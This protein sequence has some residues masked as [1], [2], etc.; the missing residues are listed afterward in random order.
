[1]WT[2]TQA[3]VIENTTRF[4]PIFTLVYPKFGPKLAV[5]VSEG[6]NSLVYLQPYTVLSSTCTLK[7][8]AFG[9]S[10]KTPYPKLDFGVS[11]KGLLEL[12]EVGPF[13]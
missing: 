8:N 13:L 10:F 6:I 5:D 9:S 7:L 3:F 1:M 2:R 4:C 12:Y 11:F